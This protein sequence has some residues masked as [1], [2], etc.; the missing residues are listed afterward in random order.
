VPLIIEDP[1]MP[2]S[3]IGTTNDEFTLNI[4]IAPTILS[5]AGIPVPS[6][7]QGRDI[8]DLYLGDDDDGR[9]AS[10][11]WRKSFFYEWTQGSPHDAE[12]HD[13]YTHIPAVFGLIRKDYKYYYWPQTKYEQLFHVEDDPCEERDA[14]RSTLT[15]DPAMLAELRGQY[16]FFKSLSQSGHAV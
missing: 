15:S 16:A 9:Q 14:F 13:E 3:K 6:Y 8:A 11:S 10:E 12:G 5:A 2:P 4:D 7:M 1:R